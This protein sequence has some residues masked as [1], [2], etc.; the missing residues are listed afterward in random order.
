M[1]T[2]STPLALADGTVTII[3]R[4]GQMQNIDPDYNHKWFYGVVTSGII[5]PT[6]SLSGVTYVSGEWTKFMAIKTH[7]PMAKTAWPKFRGNLRNTGNLADN[8]R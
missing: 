8:P 2:D 1:D 5:S 6:V 3:W 4:N 7:V